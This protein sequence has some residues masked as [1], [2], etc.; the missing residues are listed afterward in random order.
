M[1]LKLEIQNNYL[2]EINILFFL[3]TLAGKTLELYVQPTDTNR[4]FNI[5]VFLKEGIPTDQQRLIFEGKQLEDNRIFLDYNKLKES[6]LHM[7]LR[8]RGGN[9]H[10]I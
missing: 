8:L 7:V 2:Q 1:E 6:T 3:K 10:N 9:K 5:F 4:L